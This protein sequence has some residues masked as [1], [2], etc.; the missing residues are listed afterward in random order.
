[1]MQEE[2]ELH[3]FD[4]NEFALARPWINGHC[5]S[6]GRPPTDLGHVP[7]IANLPGVPFAF[8]G[9]G[10]ESPYLVIDAG[11]VLHGPEASLLMRRVAG[12]PP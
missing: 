8:C 7:C 2:G 10:C 9:H 12:R 4:P 6:C 5:T 11:V 3:L 1:M